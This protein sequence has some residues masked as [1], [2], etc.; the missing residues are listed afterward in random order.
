MASNSKM[1]GVKVGKTKSPKNSK[2]TVGAAR[3]SRKGNG[4]RGR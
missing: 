4:K 3:T 1:G 2:R